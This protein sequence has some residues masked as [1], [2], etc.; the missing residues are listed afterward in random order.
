M[1]SHRCSPCWLL[2][3][4]DVVLSMFPRPARHVLDFGRARNWQRSRLFHTAP[5]QPLPLPLSLPFHPHAALLHIPP[6]PSLP[7]ASRP[8]PPSPR[9]HVS[10]LR[11]L[12]V[13]CAKRLAVLAG[14]EQLAEEL[15]NSNMSIAWRQALKTPPR[16]SGNC[17]Q[18]CTNSLRADQCSTSGED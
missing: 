6:P 1:S 7:P 9:I 15:R 3:W 16:V 10:A 2:A 17:F 14:F 4:P 13:P 11:H 12:S 5:L 8:P 18:L